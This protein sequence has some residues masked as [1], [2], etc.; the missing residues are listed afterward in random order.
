MLE[1]FTCKAFK[2]VE[3]TKVGNELTISHDVVYCSI[4]LC[5]RRAV[6]VKKRGEVVSTQGLVHLVKQCIVTLRIYTIVTLRTYTIL[7]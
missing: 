6:I 4:N 2:I 5:F 3:R 1:R 7:H